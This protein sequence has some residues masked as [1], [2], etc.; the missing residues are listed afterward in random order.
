MK[1]SLLFVI[2]PT[3]DFHWLSYYSEELAARLL[4]TLELGNHVEGQTRV[5]MVV[6]RRQNYGCYTLTLTLALAPGLIE[7]QPWFWMRHK[8]NSFKN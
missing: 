4:T 8:N 6:V 7:N 3:K 1:L 5:I 2:F